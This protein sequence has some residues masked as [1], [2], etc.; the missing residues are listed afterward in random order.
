MK[1]KKI[2]IGRMF[3]ARAI[4]DGVG[5][6]TEAP[7]FLAFSTQKLKHFHLENEGINF[8]L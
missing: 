7:K 1:K 3:G 5:G 8:T 2:L 6:G 4:T